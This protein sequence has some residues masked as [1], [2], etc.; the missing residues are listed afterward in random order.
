MSVLMLFLLACVTGYPVGCLSV[1]MDVC[2]NDYLFACV[3]GYPAGFLSVWMDVCL[4]PYLLARVNATLL[5]PC[6]F[7]WMSAL[8]LI[9]LPV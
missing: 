4:N 8:I 1:W 9:C 2:L 7:G 5:A 6:L 3:T